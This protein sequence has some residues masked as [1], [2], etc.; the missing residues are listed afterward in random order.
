[1][2][3]MNEWQ[4]GDAIRALLAQDRGASSLPPPLAARRFA[5]PG[6]PMLAVR[7]SEDRLVRMMAAAL[8]HYAAGS[9]GCSEQDLQACG[10]TLAEIRRLGDRARL[11]LEVDNAGEE[12]VSRIAAV[13]PAPRR[14]FLDR[15]INP[16]DWC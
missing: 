16:R 7:P 4:E 3:V 1:M 10:F 13:P 6:F 11:R 8:E 12:A 14:P 2:P 5:V 15:P 9:G